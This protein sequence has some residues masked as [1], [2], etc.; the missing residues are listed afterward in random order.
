MNSVA[1]P[2]ISG[3]NMY[4]LLIREFDRLRPV[5][6]KRCRVPLPF[7][8][9]GANSSQGYWYMG[10]PPVCTH[11]CHRIMVSLWAKITT[12]YAISP[13]PRRQA[14]VNG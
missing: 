13:P 9:P 3:P 11:S 1:R 4:S 12:E 5:Q 14:T 6:C 2:V 8:G 10:T 7:W